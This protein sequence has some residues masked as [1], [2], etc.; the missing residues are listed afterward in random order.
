ME[1]ALEE[2]FAAASQAIADGA[3][4]LILSDRGVNRTH[5]PIPSLLA[6][7]GLHHHLVREGSR[8]KVGLVVE[9]G[10]AREVHHFCLLLGY[11]A[12]A[13][14]PY[15]AFKT[16][17][18]MLRQGQLNE[19]ITREKAHYHYV[20]AIIKGVVKTMSK[21]GI[22]SEEH[23]SELQSQSNLVCRLL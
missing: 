4:I 5:A 20:K 9:T 13:I 15:V 3:S 8:T 6:C 7:A 11:G 1:R 12:G 14:N 19:G 23:T 18:D 2:I 22:R 17:D 10:D 21:M 16:L